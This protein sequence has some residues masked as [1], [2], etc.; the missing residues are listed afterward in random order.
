MP[1][2]TTEMVTEDLLTVLHRILTSGSPD[3]WD[4]VL[5]LVQAWA[6]I[7]STLQFGSYE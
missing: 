2:V 1:N 3:S 4:R 6:T 7:V 5:P